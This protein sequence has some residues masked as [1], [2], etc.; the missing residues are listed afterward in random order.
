MF[1]VSK[2]LHFHSKWRCKKGSKCF[3]FLQPKKSSKRKVALHKVQKKV[4]KI[5]LRY[6]TLFTSNIIWDKSKNVKIFISPILRFGKIV[7]GK[8]DKYNFSFTYLPKYLY[9]RASV[10]GVAPLDFWWRPKLHL[11]FSEFLLNMDRFWILCRRFAPL[12]LNLL[13]WPC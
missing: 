2:Y 10:R 12:D 4:S 11:Q 6:F 5:R 1:F 3:C 7:N 9:Y 8:I 13:R